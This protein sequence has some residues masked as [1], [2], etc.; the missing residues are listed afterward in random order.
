MAL[1]RVP[2][3]GVEAPAG[4]A[5]LQDAPTTPDASSQGVSPPGDAAAA[6]GAPAAPAPPTRVPANEDEA[7]QDTDKVFP[8]DADVGAAISGLPEVVRKELGAD[9]GYQRKFLYRTSMYLGAHPRPVEHFKGIAE[10]QFADRTKLHL[11]V[12][13]ISHLLDVQS[14]IG[15]KNM[16]STG[17]G[18]ALRDLIRRSDVPP[19]GLMVHAVGYAMD[20]RAALN[21]HFKDARLVA[22]QALY[23]PGPTNFRMATGAWTT[24]RDTIKKMGRGELAENSQE[25][26][27]FITR[28]RQEGAKD[29]L[30]NFII[31]HELAATDLARLKALRGEYLQLLARRRDFLKEAAAAKRKLKRGESLDPGLSDI[32]GAVLGPGNEREK[33]LAEKLR[34]MQARRSII[35]RTRAILVGLIGKADTDI[36]AMKAIPHVAETDKEYAAALDRLG[37]RKAAAHRAVLSAERAAAKATAELNRHARAAERLK[38]RIRTERNASR[39]ARL[40]SQEQTEAAAQSSAFGDALSAVVKRRLAVSAEAS[41]GEDLDEAKAVKGKR[42]WL[43]QLEDLQR[44]LSVDDFD[45]RLVFGIGDKDAEAD[46]AVR[47]P[48]LIQLFSKGFFNVDPPAPAPAPTA[49]PAAGTS[50]RARPAGASTPLHGFDLHFM[51]EMAKHGFDQGS[52]WEAGG[53]DSMHFEFAEGVDKLHFPSDAKGGSP[54]AAAP[55]SGGT[56]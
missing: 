36:Q 35:E 48:S 17:T 52:Q 45:V 33:L 40:E 30:G 20:F 28:F 37:Q 11:H 26:T 31:T 9:P 53:V 54:K 3:A 8:T 13:A 56:P 4:D 38:A 29:L 34:I 39:R 41:A 42:R 12:D 18:F 19:P 14:V 50:A 10:F 51:E 47:D 49:A 55:S 24:R 7:R 5:P 15:A 43:G 22:V 1:Q 27:D 2:D 6:S 16:P 46:K 32:I 25:R 44:G 21:P 23:T